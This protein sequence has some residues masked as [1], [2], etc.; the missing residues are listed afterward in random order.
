MRHS[1]GMLQ[2]CAHTCT[3]Q[4]THTHTHTH[5]VTCLPSNYFLCRIK[6][7]FLCVIG[8]SFARHREKRTPPPPR[9]FGTLHVNAPDPFYLLSKQLLAIC[10]P[11]CSMHLG[12]HVC[13]T[14][15]F[16]KVLNYKTKRL[17]ENTESNQ[18]RPQE[19]L[20]PVTVQPSNICS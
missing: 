18:K 19:I 9:L 2:G 7:T 11:R 16:R 20:N 4:M 15:S 13:R 6:I 14:K 1:C 3:P 8:V 12:W 5:N 17:T 10:A